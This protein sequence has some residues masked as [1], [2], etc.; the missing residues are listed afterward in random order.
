[1]RITLLG[2]Y[3]PYPVKGGGCSSYLIEDGD[4]RILLDCGSGAMSRMLAYCPLRALDAIV[5]S[6]LHAD[7]A[8]EIDL[9]R[10]ALEQGQGRAPLPVFAPETE[11]LNATVFEPVLVTDGAEAQIGSLHLRF[12]AVRHAVPTVGVTVTDRNG[13]ALFYTGDSGWFEG[14]IDAANGADLLLADACLLDESNPK[15]L[16]N[17]MTVKQVIA[18]KRAAN[19]KRAILTHLW[20]GA[21]AYPKID[22]ETGCALAVEG[23]VYDL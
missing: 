14:L 1:M 19:A 9:V 22:P 3:G 17:H 5:L 6:H 20:G 13:R 12:T 16:Q 8:G 10:Y 4:T 18:L 11:R 23:A 21:D 15:A 7:H 2:V